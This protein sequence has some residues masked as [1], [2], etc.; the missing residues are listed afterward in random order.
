MPTKQPKWKLVAQMGDANPLE[1]GGYFIYVDETG[2][3][4]P[5]G[6]WVEVICHEKKPSTYRAYRFILENCTLTEGI[7]SDNP[8][9]PLHPT[10][11]SYNLQSIANFIGMTLENLTNLFLSDI[12]TARA[13]AWRAVGEYH[14]FENLDSYSITLTK[15]EAK[16]R[17]KI[18]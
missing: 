17:Y 3:Y 8:Y 7:L 15:A 13:I 14:G 9:H 10:W 12:A 1:Y 5:E 4:P 16:R 2:I 6:E 18:K 11:F